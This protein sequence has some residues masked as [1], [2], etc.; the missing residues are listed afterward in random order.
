MD[1]FVWTK[2][3]V[4]S[5]EGLEQIVRRK[6]AERVAGNGQFWWGIGNSLGPAVR[7]AARAQRGRVPVLFSVMLG[8]PKVADSAPENN[9]AVD[10]L[11][12]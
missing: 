9:M 10:E 12:G 8:K 6:E 4:E 5:G 3:G 7:E 2:M 1:T 11:G